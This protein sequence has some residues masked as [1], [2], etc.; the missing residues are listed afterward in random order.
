MV[1]GWNEGMMDSMYMPEDTGVHFI[2]NA[3]FPGWK[4]E[5]G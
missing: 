4:L 5:D 3:M 1:R 2:S